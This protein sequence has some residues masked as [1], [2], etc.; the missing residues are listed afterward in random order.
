MVSIATHISRANAT[1]GDIVVEGDDDD[2][3]LDDD[4]EEESSEDEID[5]KYHDTEYIGEELAEYK[6]YMDEMLRTIRNN[7]KI[8]KQMNDLSVDEVVNM[9]ESNKEDESEAESKRKKNKKKNK[10]KKKTK[11]KSESQSK[12]EEEIESKYKLLNFLIINRGNERKRCL[13]CQ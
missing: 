11:D 5:E 3:D 4:E 13:P 7:E 2:D 12:F 9:I 6:A 10:K 8:T 1:T